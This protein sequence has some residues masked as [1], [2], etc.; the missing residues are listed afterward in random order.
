VFDDLLHGLDAMGPVV[1]QLAHGALLVFAPTCPTAF[2][3]VPKVS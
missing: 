1:D 3:E 2:R